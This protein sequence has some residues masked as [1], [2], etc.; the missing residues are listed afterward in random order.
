M[1]AVSQPP[2]ES[3]HSG[4]GSKIKMPFRGLREKLHDNQPLSEARIQLNHKKQASRQSFMSRV[5]TMHQ[6]P[7]RQICKPGMLPL[8]KT[9]AGHQ[10]PSLTS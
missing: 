10:R 5:L 6:A 8:N 7:D 9:T 4:L 3:S 1:A 2:A